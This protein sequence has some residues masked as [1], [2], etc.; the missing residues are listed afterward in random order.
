[1]VGLGFQGPSLLK[2]AVAGMETMVPAPF[3]TCIT[4]L[5]KQ[6]HCPFIKQEHYQLL[7]HYTSSI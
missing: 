7:I 6:E 1:M 5:I 3:Q 4:Y 2:L